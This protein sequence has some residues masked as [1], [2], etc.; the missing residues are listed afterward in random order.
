MSAWNGLDRESEHALLRR[1]K[2]GCK[3]SAD[4]IVLEHLPL[5]RAYLSKIHV[6][7]GHSLRSDLEQAGTEGLIEALR[8]W[9]HDRPQVRFATY[10]QWWVRFKVNSTYYASRPHYGKT[11]ALRRVRGALRKHAERLRATLGREPEMDELARSIGG[12]E[13]EDVALV[14]LERTTPFLSVEHGDPTNTINRNRWQHVPVQHAEAE[15]RVAAHEAHSRVRELVHSAIT[16]LSE[17][18]RVILAQ[19]LQDEPVP[20]RAIGDQ[21]GITGEA[22]RQIEKRALAKMREM[23]SAQEEEVRDLLCVA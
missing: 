14:Y 21:L 18:E 16:R 8:H 12:C 3:A 15:D 2:E 7:R 22:V 1:A 13:P 10:A 6:K 11:R 5:V 19:R 17:R 23:L 4:R 9:D 20:L